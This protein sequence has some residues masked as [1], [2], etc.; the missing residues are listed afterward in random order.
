MKRKQSAKKLTSEKTPSSEEE[1]PRKT[2]MSK[3]KMGVCCICGETKRAHLLQKH[4]LTVHLKMNEDGPG[5]SKFVIKLHDKVYWRI[6]TVE[7]TAPV[8]ILKGYIKN[9]IDCGCGH[10]ESWSGL[11]SMSKSKSTLDGDGIED[12]DDI[13]GGVSVE[14]VLK[15]GGSLGYGVDVVSSPTYIEGEVLGETKQDITLHP[16]YN[17]LELLM[18]EKE[19]DQQKMENETFKS[20]KT[21][22]MERWNQERLAKM[23]EEEIKA[24]KL[25]NIQYKEKQ[26]QRNILESKVIKLVA[27]NLLPYYSCNYC[28]LEAEAYCSSCEWTADT[29]DDHPGFLCEKCSKKSSST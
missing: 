15:V 22:R 1:G 12:L 25:A 3:L 20:E 21:S 26:K 23:T 19:K 5:S 9:W 24:E 10:L 16:D 11:L 8:N 4:V 27:H 13:E 29:Y 2:T 14:E 18:S 6:F 7:K 28:Q 17:Y